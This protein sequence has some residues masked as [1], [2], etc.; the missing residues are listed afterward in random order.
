MVSVIAAGVVLIGVGTVLMVWK[1]GRAVV[2][3][4]IAHPLTKSVIQVEPDGNVIVARE[5]DSRNKSANDTTHKAE[6]ESK[7]KHHSHA[8]IG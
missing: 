7:E 2:T 6:E 5:S 3:E 1:A 4:S 8:V